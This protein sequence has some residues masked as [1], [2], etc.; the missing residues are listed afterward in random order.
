MSV[1]MWGA[2]SCCGAVGVLGRVGAVGT[3]HFGG[4]TPGGVTGPRAIGPFCTSAWGE[5][6]ALCRPPAPPR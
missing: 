3:L 2:L 1:A 4:V 5:A 6:I